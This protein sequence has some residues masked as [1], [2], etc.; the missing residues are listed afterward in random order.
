MATRVSANALSATGL[1]AGTLLAVGWVWW[2]YTDRDP[3]DDL[4]S[5]GNLPSV[6]DV[7]LPWIEI[8]PQK[9]RAV[10]GNKKHRSIEML[11]DRAI[12][13]RI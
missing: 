1:V 7:T 11:R 13:E 10:L 5:W 12:V 2:S 6:S 3:E 4:K 8:P 9:I